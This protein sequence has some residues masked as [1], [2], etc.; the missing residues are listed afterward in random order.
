MPF[1]CDHRRTHGPDV[2]PAACRAAGHG[3]FA[4]LRADRPGDLPAPERGTV[5]VFVLDMNHG[6]P[7]I[8]HDAIVMAVR[9]A[10]CDLTD[11]LIEAGLRV[12]VVSC[13]VRR[14]F[15]VPSL[16]D[17]RGG[18][19]LGT[20]GPGHID[21]ALNDGGDGS[22]GI[23]ESPAWETPLFTLFDAVQAH[24]DAALIGICHTFGVM[25]RWLGVADAV[26]RGSEKGGKSAGIVDTMLTPASA[27][28][29]W[30][31]ALAQ[32]V[33]DEPGHAGRIRVLDSR[34]Y[35]LM[36]RASMAATVT[37]LAFEVAADG[38][39]G[40]AVTM[41][42]SARDRTGTMP[43]VFG[44]NHHPEIVNRARALRILWD[45]RSRGEVSHE[46]YRERADAMAAT[47]RD[48]AADRGLDV[49]SRY[50]L[51]GPLRYHLERQVALRRLT[52][53]SGRPSS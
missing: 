30:F 15:A 21:P 41:W 16:P 10:A 32:A 8:G 36:P 11:V 49:T 52:P 44:V 45:K 20:G 37:P 13:D 34:L 53:G 17:G 14:G 23:V 9:T 51:F 33:A 5:D 4:F 28:H 39:A 42:E 25:S 1:D 7:N 26:R 6:W 19:Y 35:D 38:T 18:L 50:T 27:A 3:V 24:P 46:W 47:L 2:C 31:G 40:E 22:Q 12:R 29:P 43:R 48:D